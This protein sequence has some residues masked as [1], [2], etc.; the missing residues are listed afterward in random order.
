M[1]RAGYVWDYVPACH[2]LCVW[3]IGVGVGR[4]SHLSYKS[5]ADPRNQA[6]SL[7]F[8]SGRP[9]HGQPCLATYTPPF[10]LAEQPGCWEASWRSL[11]ATGHF[12]GVGQPLATLI[13]TTNEVGVV[14]SVF[15][16]INEQSGASKVDRLALA[17]APAGRRKGAGIRTHAS[18]GAHAPRGPALWFPG[19]RP[20]TFLLSSLNLSPHLQNGVTLT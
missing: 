9:S 15:T 17:G 2:C 7:H 8:R 1:D 19:R 20:Q 18:D 11:W 3:G 6:K 4:A 12:L 13:L 14:R 5:F 16:F 10:L